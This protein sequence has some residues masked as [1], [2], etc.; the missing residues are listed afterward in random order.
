VGDFKKKTEVQKNTCNPKWNANLSFKLLENPNKTDTIQIK[1][2]NHDRAKKSESVGELDVSYA[3]M[4]KS[5]RDNNT[6]WFPLSG[7]KV[8][9]SRIRLGFVFAL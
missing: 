2:L 1:I 8:K 7:K 3:Q 5:F 6:E 4:L 9:N